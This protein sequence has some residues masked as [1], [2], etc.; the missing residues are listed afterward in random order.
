MTL[1]SE[2]VATVRR[3]DGLAAL[4]H[5]SRRLLRLLIEKTFTGRICVAASFGA[6]SAVLLHLVAA[7]DPAIPVIF[8]NTGK[9]FGETLRYRNRMV[10]RL[11]L[12]DVRDVRP[13]PAYV[14]AEDPAGR[15][16][17]TDADR[18]CYLRKVE[19]FNLA[20]G[21]FDAVITGRKAFHGGFRSKLETLEAS[22]DGKIRVN[23]LLA[24]QGHDLTTYAEDND[25]PAHP[26]RADGYASIGC[27]PCTE[28]ASARA[29]RWQGQDKTECG[30]HLNATD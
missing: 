26:L 16:W 11:G 24:W 15:L 28:P 1:K 27:V 22:G 29:G 3:D 5:E 17:L 10:A 18:C 13:D 2:D 19:P 21:D 12:L 23:P 4:V 6:E 7:I 14:A 30:I 25:L 20:I 9:L 8:G